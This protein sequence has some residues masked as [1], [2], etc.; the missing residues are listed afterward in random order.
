[1]KAKGILVLALAVGLVVMG[2]EARAL[3][4]NVD[5][6]MSISSPSVPTFPYG[7]F[8]SIM[9]VDNGDSIDI[10]AALDPG[11]SHSIAVVSLNWAGAS[12]STTG[13][14]VSPGVS[15]TVS[16][17][18]AGWYSQ[19]DFRAVDSLPYGNP[20]LF[21]LSKSGTDLDP[22][23]FYAKDEYGNVYGVVRTENENVAYGATSVPEPMTMLL[24]GA[25]LLGLAAVRRVKK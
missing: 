21:T 11:L 22:S 16:Q 3:T 8:G 6:T 10:T 18:N 13:W 12:L 17:N 24:L 20:L 23:D 14:S 19:F 7:A 9:L 5:A 15:L 4:F 1:M 2:G 25:G